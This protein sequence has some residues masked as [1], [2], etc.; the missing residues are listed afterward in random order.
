MNKRDYYE[1][2]GVPRDATDADIKKA[3]RKLALQH[4]PDRTNGDKG[5]EEKFKE[6]NE[7]Y[8]VLSNQEKR[9]QYDT[10]GHNFERMGGMGHEDIFGSTVFEDLIGDVF[11]DFFG[12]RRS[13]RSRKFRGKDIEAELDL[14]FEE[15]VMGADKEFTVKRTVACTQCSG[16]GAR[17]GTKPS[18]CRA[19]HG[20]G[21]INYR[22]GFLTVTKTCHACNGSGYEIIDKCKECN[23]TG[24][25][26][27]E[28]K[29]KLAQEREERK[30]QG[31][32]AS[33]SASNK[34]STVNPV[35]SSVPASGSASSKPSTVTTVAPPESAPKSQLQQFDPQTGSKWEWGV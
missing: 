14:T 17:T 8:S 35:S 11:S 28:E 34:P 25:V 27:K 12:G 20:S 23:G 3:Y 9:S 29:I 21:Q 32:T 26:L 19:C 10:Y 30:K 18:V 24:R 2:L 31:S 1:I 13:S 7:A 22:Q 16:T 15:A 33:A 4:H 6:I 5:S